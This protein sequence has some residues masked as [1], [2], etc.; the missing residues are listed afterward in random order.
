METRNKHE[1]LR[2]GGRSKHLSSFL[3]EEREE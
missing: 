1:N 2:K 3:L